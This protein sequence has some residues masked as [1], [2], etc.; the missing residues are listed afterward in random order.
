MSFF[1]KIQNIS[2]QIGNCS[3]KFIKKTLENFQA[4]LWYIF[5]AGNF[6]RET[7][8]HQAEGY[9]KHPP[10]SADSNGMRFISVKLVVLANTPDNHKNKDSHS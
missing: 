2:P 7:A 5:Q 1:F 3:P 8:T 10:W 4:L 6:L 9:K